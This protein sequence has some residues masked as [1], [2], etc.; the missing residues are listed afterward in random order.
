MALRDKRSK[1][2]E[3][4]TACLLDVHIPLDP[5]STLHALGVDS[6]QLSSLEIAISETF[7]GVCI[8]FGMVNGKKTFNDLFEYIQEAKS[9][10][11][12]SKVPSLKG[13]NSEVPWSE[14]SSI[15]HQVSIEGPGDL[16]FSKI[17]CLKNNV[18]QL[19]INHPI[20][21]SLFKKKKKKTPILPICKRNGPTPLSPP[22]VCD[23]FDVQK[24]FLKRENLR[25][26]KLIVS[27]TKYR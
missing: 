24:K 5:D 18:P 4:L 15:E 25:I 21:F 8:P 16:E 14:T 7:P 13:S 10:E 20:K 22:Q 17:Q 2:R 12:G 6:I 19:P 3:I 26:Q 27:L 11:Q 23:Q 1:T 9:G